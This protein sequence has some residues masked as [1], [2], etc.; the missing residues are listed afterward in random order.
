MSKTYFCCCV[1]LTA[2]A[3]TGC[4]SNQETRTVEAELPEAQ[5]RLMAINTAYMQFQEKYKRPPQN[6]QELRGMLEAGSGDEVLRS[7][8]DGQPFAICYGVDVF[9]PLEW[10]QSTPVLAYE[11]GGE[12]DRWVLAIPGAVYCLEEQEF[13]QSSF[14]PG[15]TVK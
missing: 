4:G 5:S 13:R 10:A 11:Q 15:H 12:G 3:L 2:A 14:P 8:R 6:E 1:L 7:P 9:G